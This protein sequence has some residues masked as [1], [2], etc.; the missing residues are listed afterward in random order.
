MACMVTM[1][2]GFEKRAKDL[3][4]RQK[5]RQRLAA[6]IAAL[7]VLVVAGISLML[8]KSGFALTEEELASWEQSATEVTIDIQLPG[9]S[10]ETET[11]SGP[12]SEEETAS[13][14]DEETVS[15]Q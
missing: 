7:A 9:T 4:K 12:D 2:S 5:T 11:A 14:K 1:S 3:I 13:E 6:I 15:V 8:F 10:D